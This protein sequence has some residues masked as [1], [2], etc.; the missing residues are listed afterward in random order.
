MP[1]LS[2]EQFWSDP[3]K[4]LNKILTASCDSALQRSS[5]KRRQPLGERRN[6]HQQTEP[7]QSEPP[8]STH[9]VAQ[10][11]L[12]LVQPP[13][14]CVPTADPAPLLARL[15]ELGAQLHAS[16]MQLNHLRAT[17][18][19]LSTHV[20]TLE[21][22]SAVAL[23]R[24]HTAEERASLLAATAVAATVDSAGTTLPVLRGKLLQAA[25]QVAQAAATQLRRATAHIRELESRHETKARA[26]ACEAHALREQLRLACAQLAQRTV[27]YAAQSRA[28]KEVSSSI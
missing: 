7:C 11:D 19:A 25:R 20:T 8:S 28:A 21:E 27:L 14:L 16:Q 15:A 12:P 24:A 10:E 9:A 5:S 23:H 17:S 6:R 13:Q 2:S 26:A 3:R 1:L 4:E 18:C 22:E